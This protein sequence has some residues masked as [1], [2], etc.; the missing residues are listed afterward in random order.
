M[1]FNNSGGTGSGTFVIDNAAIGDG[2]HPTGDFSGTIGDGTATGDFASGDT[3]D[4]KDVAYTP[5]TETDVWVQGSVL[6]GS[7]T[8][9][10]YSGSTA[11]ATLTLAGNYTQNGFELQ[12]DTGGGTTGDTE[13]VWNPAATTNSFAAGSISFENGHWVVDDGIVTLSGVDDVTDRR[14]DL[15]PGR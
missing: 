2:G 7:G 14:Q 1:T 9:T 3:I 5:G 10:I 4:L 11:E 12:G 8:L 13:V 15:P 6:S